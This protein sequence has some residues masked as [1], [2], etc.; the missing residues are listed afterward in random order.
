[1][2]KA[3]SSSPVLF[4]YVDNSNVWIEG[5]RLSAVKKGLARDVRDATTRGIFDG[6][7]T[8]DFGR[9]YQIACPDGAHIGRSKLWGSRPPANDSLW[10]MARKQGFEVQVYDRNAGGKEKKVDTAIA[11]RMVRDASKF[12]DASRGDIAVL[13]G[14]DGDF[15]P[16]FEILKE[17][18]IKLQIVFWEHGLSGEL[19]AM[20]D[21]FVSLDRHFDHLTRIDTSAL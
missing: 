11:T 12:M 4:V 6:S 20:A 10:D 14:G 1:M 15:V 17:D 21:E 8:Y 7:W 19:R 16:A 3:K 13:V 9:L 18:D 5:Q 2:A